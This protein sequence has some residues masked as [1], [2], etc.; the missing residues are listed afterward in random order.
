MFIGQQR[1]AWPESIDATFRQDSPLNSGIRIPEG[2]SR[3]LTGLTEDARRA[4]ASDPIDAVF[5][6]FRKPATQQRLD[7]PVTIETTLAIVE[8][9]WDVSFQPDRGAPAKTRFVELISWAEDA[10]AGVKYFSGTG[11]YTKTVQAPPEWFAGGV[12][13]WIDLGSVKNLAEVIV[14]GGS[15]GI[16]WKAPFRIDVTEALKPVQRA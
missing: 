3:S 8:G 12:R 14:N 15:M 16:V 2:L 9:P 4:A 10:N 5:V 1:N 7:V 6:V 11:T 13:L